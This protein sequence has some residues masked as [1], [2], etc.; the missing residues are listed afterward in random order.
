MQSLYVT[1]TSCAY[2]FQEGDEAK[3][4]EEKEFFGKLEYSLDYNFNDNQVECSLVCSSLVK[5]RTYLY[6]KHILLCNYP[7]TDPS[8]M[9]FSNEMVGLY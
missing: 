5:T 2:F 9:P 3:E 6:L 8:L 4:E 7:N 1:L